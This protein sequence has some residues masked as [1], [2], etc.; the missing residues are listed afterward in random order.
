MINK[1]GA[2]EELECRTY[3]D[4]QA[5]LSGGVDSGGNSWIAHD[6]TMIMAD[7]VIVERELQGWPRKKKVK[8]E[9]STT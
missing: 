6:P 3:M 8:V 2:V 7:L 4:A 5:Y 9:E 1:K